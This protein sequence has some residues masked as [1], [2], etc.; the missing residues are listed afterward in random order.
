MWCGKSCDVGR[1]A[2]VSFGLA[3]GLTAFFGILI[4]HLWM[5][6]Y[7]VPPE[8]VKF[9]VM[10]LTFSAGFIHALL[11]LFE[12]FIFGLFV[13]IFYN[14]SLCC[15]SACCRASTASCC[16]AKDMSESEKK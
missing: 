8:M 3:F 9:V 16:N 15:K 5:M 7:G 1:L 10:P 4:C 12:G 2:P 13:A 14:L 11:G 6:K